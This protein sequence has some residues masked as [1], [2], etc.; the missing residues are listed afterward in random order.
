M[1]NFIIGRK[2]SSTTRCVHS[3]LGQR[4][5]SGES[6]VLIVPKQFT[7]DSDKGILELLGP[8]LAS[9]VEV[10]SFSRLADVVF[11]QYRGVGKPIL[12][13]TA[14]AVMLSLALDSLK[15]KLDVFSRHASSVAFTKKMLSQIA[16]L[17]KEAV[18]PTELFEA[19]RKMGDCLLKKKTYETALIY[20]TYN[21]LLNESFF[22]DR[23]LLSAVCDVLSESDFFDNRVIA[24]D[25]FSAFS[26]QELKIIELA[27]KRAK[28]VYVTLCCDDLFSANSLSPFSSV[29]RT[30][31]RLSRAAAKNGVEVGK[32][33]TLSNAEGVN[34]FL[35]PEIGYLESELY[36]VLAKPYVGSCD[37]V[38]VVNAPTVREE[39]EFVASKI[40]NLLRTG[41]YRCRDIAVVYR[42]G[43]T[44][45]REMRHSL[46]KYGV[47]IFEDKRADVQNEPLCVFVRA[48][49][50]MVACGIN[51]ESL[52]KY[53][54]TDLSA[55]SHDEV[56]EIENYVILW[57][58]D[59][60]ALCREWK[61]NPDGFGVELN[62]RRKETLLSLNESRKKLVAPI[63][64]LRENCRNK[65]AVDV[66]KFVFNFLLETGVNE[67]LKSYAVSLEENGQLGSALEQEQIW[68]IIVSV[69]D[70]MAAVL[71]DS[72][73]EPKR[74]LKLFEAALETQT[75]GKLPDGYDEVYICDAGRIQTKMA[76]VV[77]V[78]GANENVFPAAMK[79]GGIFTDSE[80]EKLRSLVPD[81]GENPIELV[82][83]ER[84]LVYCSLCSAKKQLFVSY[85]LTDHSGAKLASSQIVTLIKKLFPSVEE[86]RYPYRDLRDM[87]E[88]ET[89]AFEQMAENWH[90]DTAEEKT[91]KKYFRSKD[92]YRGR[93]A[94]IERANDSRDFAF[95]RPENAKRLF[96]E[97][98]Y[99]SASQLETFES[100][101]FQYFCRYGMG[102][103]ERK[104]AEL[105][106]ANIGTVVHSVLERLLSNHRGEKIYSLTQSEAEAEIRQYLKEYMDKFMGS[107]QERSSRFLYLYSRLYK[108][109]AAIAERLLS[110]FDNS[111]FSPVDF[112]LSISQKQGVSPLRINLESGFVELHGVV[113]RVDIMQKD[114]KTYLR[115]VDYKT[116][117][118]EFS[119]SD[120]LS[121]L[122]MQML[123]YLVSI[124]KNGTERY[125]EIVPSGVLYLPARVEPFTVDNG[126]DPEIIDKKRLSGGKMSGMLLNDE[127][128]IS[129]MDESE[130]YRFIPVKYSHRESRMVGNLISLQQL[131][132][133]TEKLERIMANMGNDL[134]NG[135]IPALPAYGKGHA[136]TCEWCSFASVCQREK[137]G[138]VRYIE[139]LTHEECLKMLGAK[140]KEK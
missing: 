120:V 125:G 117:K 16:A 27:M 102:A 114:G 104:V 38:K 1:L 54:K 42:E 76:E 24:F 62:E 118:K 133:L 10:L 11:K 98:L 56:A 94:A 91:L 14:S 136:Q 71:K 126:E 92:E 18:E 82:A 31:A 131:E 137:N 41:G 12:K 19:S 25:G 66:L 140:E 59:N 63:A 97:T 138:K 37:A 89:A 35:S 90:N 55:L 129:G 32:S 83:K 47:P 108:L 36:N 69:F 103:K 28:D 132:N 122:G 5:E 40:H 87:L 7:F 106:A 75:L 51:T 121:G 30:A 15:E 52:L 116:G 110:E 29:R 135:K 2:G 57:D 123:L 60:D 73:V 112:E 4:C 86:I 8:R 3:L 77:F 80:N 127:T 139:K 84:F 100:C 64:A 67:R 48:L 113:D 107:S 45:Q 79:N 124:W 134:H 81:F 72:V 70:D 33:I 22:D 74:L 23:D 115:I 43:E 46:K 6:V 17:K 50:E 61:D 96:G 21:T 58:L 111:S 130:S 95:D 13:D 9:E 39:C 93:V 88:C 109:L 85:S 128:A 26:G 65:C 119:L 68:N 105:D 101:P 49:F 99:L 20:E 78:V 34:A 44:Y 53:A